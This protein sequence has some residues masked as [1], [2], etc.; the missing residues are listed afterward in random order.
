MENT[1][2][3]NNKKNSFNKLPSVSNPKKIPK[4]YEY[5]RHL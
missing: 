2:K 4:D 1:S 3:F 5:E